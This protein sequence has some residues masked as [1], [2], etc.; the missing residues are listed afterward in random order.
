MRSA[1][2][3]FQGN[4]GIL[5]TGEGFPL[6]L[7][8]STKVGLVFSFSL[9]VSTKEHFASGA[10]YILSVQGKQQIELHCGCQIDAV[11]P[12]PQAACSSPWSTHCHLAALPCQQHCSGT[13]TGKGK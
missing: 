3:S 13:G 10:L 6:H 7:S 8:Q 9:E 12:P 4:P 2:R 1:A 11:P 5:G